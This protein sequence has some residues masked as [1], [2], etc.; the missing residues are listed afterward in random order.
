MKKYPFNKWLYS[1]T[2]IGIFFT[3]F[4]VNSCQHDLEK[5]VNWETGLIVPLLNG[6]MDIEDLVA[7]SLVSTN[8]DNSMSIVYRN[9]IYNLLISDIVVIPDTTLEYKLALDS[10][11]LSDRVI[12]KPITLGNM[13][14]QIGGI[15]G[16]LI[17]ASNGK[18]M[19]IPPLSGLTSS[20]PLDATEYFETMTL[21]A[22]WMDIKAE[23][24]L[25]IDVTNV[26]FMLK[27]KLPPSTVFQD[28]FTIIP[29][30][31][32]RTKTIDLAGKTI[33]GELIFDIINMDS[34]GTMPDSAIIDTSDAL[35]VTITIRDLKVFSATAIFP[36]QDII[37]VPQ[38]VVYG[39]D[40]AE[41]TFF[42]IKSGYLNVDA[43]STI[44]DSIYFHFSVPKATDP[45]NQQ[46]E[47]YTVCPPAP[48]GGS[49]VVSESHDL[50]N[51]DVDLTGLAGDTFNLFKSFIV[52]RIDSTGRMVNISL[53]DSIYVYYGMVD[54]IPDHITG[55][56]DDTIITHSDVVTF[57]LF[58]HVKGG[59]I[60]L[61]KL[62]LNLTVENEIGIDGN[63]RINS[64][65]S[66]NNNTGNSV[67]LSGSIVGKDNIIIRAKD[68]TPVTAGLTT[69][70][71]DNSN[72]N[73]I[74]LI[75]NLPNVFEYDI[76]VA[77]NPLG[78][79]YGR[80]DFAYYNS[81]IDV[82]LDLEIPLS[83]VANKLLLSDTMD[84]TL[85]NTTTINRVKS[86]A[87]KL[88]IDNGYPLEADIQIYLYNSNWDL[89][90]S[91]FA[92]THVK[93]GALNNNCRVNGK[94]RSQ[95]ITPVDEARIAKLRTAVK[96]IIIAEFS[97]K[98]AKC[99][100][101][102]VKIYSDYGMDIK[103]IGDFNYLVNKQN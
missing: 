70:K 34:P 60:D 53:L 3:F 81:K 61:E 82:S 99:N 17:I 4:A 45:F 35:I 64:L 5:N 46:L 102:W 16:A 91:L 80:K 51:Y 100:N 72:S 10:L 76:E 39:M 26:D 69:I 15:V 23:N 96:A 79:V 84:F 27:N 41:L 47:A 85:G 71:M 12:V 6:N 95:L 68:G 78:D 49:A 21:L 67:A 20:A 30:G 56:F 89:V 31:G 18:Y 62:D 9:S 40:G 103:L 93:A 63:I 66:I 29:A 73:G 36:A 94:V 1:A 101:T 57:D 98:G 25:P 97:G 22:G 77:I 13:A 86:G 74:S 24:G 33:E 90:D 50:A 88:L 38:D 44:E 7:D 58:N 42:E 43:V 28:S 59:S 8:A 48:P 55:Y 52:G 14:N 65:K 83:L 2:V 37:N 54:I 87:I 19:V 92:N 75:E 32:T 11:K